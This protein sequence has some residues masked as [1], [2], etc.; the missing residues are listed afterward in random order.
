MINKGYFGNIVKVIPI[1]RAPS[2]SVT[3]ESRWIG[4]R[5]V[6]IEYKACAKKNLDSH[7]ISEMPA[8]DIN[9]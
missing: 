6:D 1:Y 4:K 8:L 9:D 3:F 2:A 7:D 5:R